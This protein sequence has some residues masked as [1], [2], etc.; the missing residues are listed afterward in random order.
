VD[1]RALLH[2]EVCHLPAFEW[3]RFF[4]RKQA[5]ENYE[6]ATSRERRLV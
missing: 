5:V 1:F 2:K 3:F 6:S 4:A